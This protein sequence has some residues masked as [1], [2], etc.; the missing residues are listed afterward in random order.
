[1]KCL[2]IYPCPTESKHYR[3]GFSI[4]I[5]YLSAIL[6]MKLS[7]DNYFFDLS[8]QNLSLDYIVDFIEKRQIDLVLIDFDSYSLKRAENSISGLELTDSIKAKTNAKIIAFGH[9]CSIKQQKIANADY[10][11]MSDP[12][13]SIC[14]IITNFFPQLKIEDVNSY[15]ELPLPDRDLI[16]QIPYYKT[17]SHCNLIQTS[18]GCLNG[19]SFCQRRAWFD[20]YRTHSIEYVISEFQ[21]LKSRGVKNLWVVDDNFSFNLNRAKRLLKSLIETGLTEGMY[22][23][24]SSWINIDHEFLDLASK[25]NVKVMSFGLENG[26]QKVLDFYNKNITRDKI[27]DIIFYANSKGI[28]TVGNFIIGSPIE[29]I[30]MVNENFAFIESLKLDQVNIKILDYMVGSPLFDTLPKVMKDNNDHYF[31]CK[32]N[33]LSNIS[34]DNLIRLKKKFLSENYKKSQERLKAK[35]VKFGVP[36]LPIKNT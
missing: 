21:D 7:S 31:S 23:A 20:E 25:A 34:I 2:F 24:L 29:T 17:N 13:F 36:Y 22:I 30:D 15:D 9:L 28:F 19:C 5:A 11:C 16:N 32:E 33:G 1:M 4:N 18:Q 26:S 35:I 8:C 27:S 3:F 10:T 12:R 14:Q 6:K